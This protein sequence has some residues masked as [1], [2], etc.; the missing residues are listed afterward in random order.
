MHE[1]RTIP[2]INI[3]YIR[4]HK[5]TN[6]MVGE[7]GLQTFKVVVVVLLFLML[8]FD[9]FFST[10]AHPLSFLDKC[11]IQIYLNG[12]FW[13]KLSY[14]LLKFS[15]DQYDH[16]NFGVSLILDLC[17]NSPLNISR[18]LMRGKLA[19]RKCRDCRQQQEIFL[20][21]IYTRVPLIHAT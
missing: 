2:I 3:M 10:N 13:F 14:R 19:Q 11:F 21:L 1:F 16:L 4:S 20:M 17:I 5:Y 15:L 7:H 9:V 18:F 8:L 12:S 6:M